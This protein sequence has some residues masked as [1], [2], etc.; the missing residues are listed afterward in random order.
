MLVSMVAV[1][2]PSEYKSMLEAEHWQIIE[3]AEVAEKPELFEYD[4]PLSK[5]L[6]EHTHALCLEYRIP[7]ELVIAVIKCESD[8][9][10]KCIG[11]GD[12]GIMQINW[13][14]H[15][16]TFYE[17]GYD[18]VFDPYQN[19]A[20]GID[21]LAGFYHKYERDEHATLI[22]YNMGEKRYKELVAEGITESEYSKN[23]LTYKQG[24]L[25]IRYQ[26]KK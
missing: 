23:V 4:I 26:F 3:E 1:C 16:E 20:Y 6:Q 19:I 24:L 11:K 17:A 12:Y 25:D 15:K 18:D 5:E 2:Q 21:Y 9:D 7:Y 10:S 13:H 14:F 8:F 22:C